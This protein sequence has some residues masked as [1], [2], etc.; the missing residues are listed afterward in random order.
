MSTLLFKLGILG[1][2]FILICSPVNA[3]IV[4]TTEIDLA[5]NEVVL[6]DNFG[7]NSGGTVTISFTTNALNIYYAMCIR[8]DYLTLSNYFNSG[9]N[10]SACIRDLNICSSVFELYVNNS[11]TVTFNQTITVQGEYY[12]I[13]DNCSTY[14][15]VIYT[16]YEFLN[17]GGEQL[18]FEYIPLP[19][20]GLSFAILW[21]ILTVV[22]C[23]NWIY[24][25]HQNI[26][27]HKFISTIFLF[28][29]ARSAVLYVLFSN[30]SSTGYLNYSLFILYISA[31]V[32]WYFTFY[33]SLLLISKG[34][35]IIVDKLTTKEYIII[36]FLSLAQAVCF[37]IEYFF[38]AVLLA[39]L[40]I[41]IIIFFLIFRSTTTNINLLNGSIANSEQPNAEQAGPQEQNENKKRKV[42]ML[43]YFLWLTLGY[44]F[45]SFI[46]GA[47]F[48][49]IVDLNTIYNW[50]DFLYTDIVDL[51]FF[52]G[53]AWTLRLRGRH[54]YFLLDTEEPPVELRNIDNQAIQQQANEPDSNVAPS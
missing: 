36:F 6:F 34:Y 52:I 27:L 32:L 47:L 43:R 5:V 53:I 13:L 8:G 41:D 17:P 29:I 40:V 3:I 51:L 44:M 14:D 33:S 49:L 24:Y 39:T 50:L 9:I 48:S 20:L 16:N 37:F 18:P 42:K 2:V 7:F 19:K 38:I 4:D 11:T 23:A 30:Y 1:A 26:K 22:W 12:F 31:L 35:C 28:S 15:A 10:N 25:R 54:I 45:L 46:V 21:S